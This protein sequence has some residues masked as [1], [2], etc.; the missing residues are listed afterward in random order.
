MLEWQELCSRAIW[1]T[2]GIFVG[3]RF[4]VGFIT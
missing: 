1:V 4:V 2:V 3:F